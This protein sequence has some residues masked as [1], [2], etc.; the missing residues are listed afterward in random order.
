[1]P[2]SENM[3]EFKE[4]AKDEAKTIVKDITQTIAGA[5]AKTSQIGHEQGTMQAITSDLSGV[6]EIVQV[7]P[8]QALLFGAAGLVPYVG[9]SMATIY[10]A[11]QAALASSP[12]NST[13][14]LE[15]AMALLHHTENIQVGYGAIILSFIGAIHWG[16]EFAKFGGQQGTPRYLLGI[17]PVLVAMPT[18]L[19][20][21]TQALAAQWA[22]FAGTWWMD[23]RATTNGWTPKWY[24]T[25]RFWLTAMVGSSILLTLGG[26]NY[27]GPGSKL[28][29]T[30]RRLN[31]INQQA[32][33]NLASSQQSGEGKEGHIVK[34]KMGGD[35]DMSMTSDAYIKLTNVAKKEEEEEK[36]KEEAEKK[37]KEEKANKEKEAKAKKEESKKAEEKQ[38][39]S[40]EKT[41]GA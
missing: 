25:Y 1:M 34:G 16:L 5:N 10:C 38:K 18:L 17:A 22:A 2:A 20:P 40:G 35:V 11:H 15:T 6:K 30:G 19:L 36:Q 24:S 33:N 41:P 28:A 12:E 4:N 31:E 14:D 13:L 9:T 8:N 26:T 27:F 32:A 29:T 21:G 37:E 7:V 39:S 3:S 23:Q